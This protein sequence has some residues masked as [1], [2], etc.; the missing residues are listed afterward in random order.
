M[1]SSK[2][3]TT[4]RKHDSAKGSDKKN[5]LLPALA[6]VV[7]I[8]IVAAVAYE[9]YSNY[10][11]VN[12]NTFKANFDSATRVAI[13]ITYQNTS[14]LPLL[15]PCTDMLV[16]V[17]AHSR[18][19]STIDFFILNKTSCAYS[20]TGLGHAINISTKSA[21]SCLSVADSEPSVFLNASQSNSTVI[22]P[23][24]FYQNADPSYL[25]KC[26]IAAEFG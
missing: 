15:I 13:A 2:K 6:V 8:I 24:H 23:Y 22:L 1:A 10:T 11:Y 7:V 14:N 16:Q 26:A 5:Q 21:S 12:F 4:S 9:A 19:A 20:P 17:I 3:E 18:N 25:S